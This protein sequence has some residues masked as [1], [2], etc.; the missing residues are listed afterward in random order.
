[1]WRTALFI[2]FMGIFSLFGASNKD[3]DELVL[4]QLKKAGS[5]LSKPH[6]I[7]FFLYLPSEA[8]ANKAASQI[9]DHG[10]QAAVQPPLKTAEWLCFATKTMVPELSELQRIRRDFERL[11]HELGGNYDGWGTE[12]E[13]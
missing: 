10:F 12:V 13:K 8:S 3:P 7:E 2:L 11:T 9:R 4:I 6:G 5:D 1:M